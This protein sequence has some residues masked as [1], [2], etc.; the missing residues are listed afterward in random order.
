VG[1]HYGLTGKKINRDEG[2]VRKKNRF[3][4]QCCFLGSSPGVVIRN[5]INQLNIRGLW[6]RDI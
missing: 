4:F 3:S 2:R 5:S 1:S 6:K